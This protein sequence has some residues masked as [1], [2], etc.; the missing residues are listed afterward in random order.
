VITIMLLL[1]GPVRSVFRGLPWR[2]ILRLHWA[3]G[4]RIL[5]NV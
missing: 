4:T 1:V 5:G 2:E 3:F